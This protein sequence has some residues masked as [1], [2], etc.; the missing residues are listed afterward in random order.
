MRLSAY[1]PKPAAAPATST[2][3]MSSARRIRFTS[4]RLRFM[5]R[6]SGRC[7]RPAVEIVLQDDRGRRRVETGLACPP[8]LFA[9]RQATLGLDARQALVLENDR[10]R[11]PAAKCLRERLDAR[12]HLVGR[13]I[14]PARQ[15]NDQRDQAIL[16]VGEAR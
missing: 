16:L 15:S 1:M 5:L 14:E 7:M 4:D 6:F 2:T 10:Q 12:R 8:V 11:C 13:S 3:T 9:S